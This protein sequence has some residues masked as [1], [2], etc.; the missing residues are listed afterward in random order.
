MNPYSNNS[1][2]VITGAF[3][4]VY[5]Q[6]GHGRFALPIINNRFDHR[7]TGMSRNEVKNVEKNK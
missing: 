7:K 6:T 4:R 5:K 1:K 3:S 2:I